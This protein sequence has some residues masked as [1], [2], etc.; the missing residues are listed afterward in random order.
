MLRKLFALLFAGILLMGI[1]MACADAPEDD[2][3]A[4]LKQYGYNSWDEFMDDYNADLSPDE[5]CPVHPQIYTSPRYKDANKDQG[6]DLKNGLSVKQIQQYLDSGTREFGLYFKFTPGGADNNYV[7]ER[8]D[9]V[10]SDPS[11]QRVYTDGFSQTMT[12][13]KGYYWSINFLSLN[14][15]FQKLNS[16]RGS[17][18]TGRYTMDIYFNRLWTGSITFV[19]NK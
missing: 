19:V 7:I 15:L 1:G 2:L 9:F 12:C 6:Y 16:E 5:K 13:E 4:M 18:P 11:G 3:L 10:I 17:I 8:M 14:G